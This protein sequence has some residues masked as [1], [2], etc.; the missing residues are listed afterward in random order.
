MSNTIFRQKSLDRISSPEQLNEYIRVSTPSVWMLLI[1][2][3]ILLIGVCVWGVFG[4]MDTTLSAVAVAENG[5][6]TAYVRAEDAAKVSADAAAAVGGNTGRVLSVSAPPV[7]VDDTFTD[8]MRHA[9]GLEEG[10]WVYALTLEADCADGVYT[11]QI[12][13]DSVSPMS[14][15]L[16]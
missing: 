3:V 15:V 8:Y 4:Q 6:V 7:A 5:T 11:A 13:I 9:G 16:N 10:E 14:F 1:A 12:V 2:I